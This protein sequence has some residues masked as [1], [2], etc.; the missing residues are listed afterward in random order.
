MNEMGDQIRAVVFVIVALI[1]L[2]A[3]GHFYKPAD[4]AAADS[5]DIHTRS[6]IPSARQY[7]SKRGE[8]A[9][10]CGRGRSRWFC[11]GGSVKRKITRHRNSR[12]CGRILESWRRSAKLEA[13]EIF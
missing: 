4:T 13:E 10:D 3:W 9:A 12:L 8:A 7:F 2:F 5:A 11:K 1:I 6:Y